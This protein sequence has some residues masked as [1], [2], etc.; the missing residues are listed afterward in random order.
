[1]LFANLGAGLSRRVRER[2]SFLGGAWGKR[3]R[4][5]AF[6]ASA[7]LPAAAVL[8]WPTVYFA[9]K[10]MAKAVVAVLPAALPSPPPKPE[11]P[12]PRY[13]KPEGFD[14]ANAWKRVVLKEDVIA[15]VVGGSPFVL[16]HRE[17]RV[18]ALVRR[19][20]KSLLVARHLID[21]VEDRQVEIA[22][23]VG[24][25]AWSPDDR[26]LIAA[27]ADGGFVVI[28]W[29]RATVIPLPI[30]KADRK[31][32]NDVI[33]WRDED[34]VVTF[35]Q[36]QPQALSLDTLRLSPLSEHPVWAK[37]TEADRSRVFASVDPPHPSVP[38]VRY[39]FA[40]DGDGLSL[41]ARDAEAHYSRVLLP[42]ISSLQ[43]DFWNRDGSIVFFA[44]RERLRILYMGLRDA[45]TLRF[46]AESREGFP[47]TDEVKAAIKNRTIE[48]FITE[49]IV[50]PLNGKT[51]AGDVAHAKG[52]ARVIAAEGKA[53][54]IW[55]SEERGPIRE[56]DVITL[57]RVA[58]P[59][60]G[61]P[62]SPTWFAVLTKA[63][64]SQDIP[65]RDS[66]K[67]SATTNDAATAPTSAQVSPTTSKPD[68]PSS[69][70]VYDE[71]MKHKAEWM[72]KKEKNAPS[73]ETK[74]PQPSSVP[75]TKSAKSTPPPTFASKV[76]PLKANAPPIERVKHFITLHHAKVSDRD[77]DGI[78]ADYGAVAHV[79]GKDM[80]RE[81]VRRDEQTV[82]AN[83]VSLVEQVDGP[84][85]VTTQQNSRYHAEYGISFELIT[86]DDNGGQGSALVEMDVLLTSAG[87][88]IVARKTRVYK[89]GPAG[90][91]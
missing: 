17:D 24:P 70:P 14:A 80:T 21:P 22:V 52:V 50:N 38:K 31:T 62:L 33:W 67:P 40:R 79:N 45:P 66:E 13:A 37:L 63:D 83:S 64:A 57:P 77:I 34:V 61:A 4:V 8:V 2:E 75:Q 49:P 16:S 28:D 88:K 39:A 25:M 11:P 18:A 81:D 12:K 76:P 44:E 90:K 47:A 6:A 85:A 32:L 27:T 54:T 46:A 82:T 42:G 68:A 26:R 86:R 87:P 43:V 65:R 19:N 20:G 56:G 9:D 59:N 74:P 51:V 84:I 71:L 72:P 35:R 58:S 55:V 53:A 48:C 69:R 60:G 15:D 1:M 3:E 7:V 5:F 73:A 78:A 30:P 29:E 91:R 41:L 89:K 23:A 10:L 36:G